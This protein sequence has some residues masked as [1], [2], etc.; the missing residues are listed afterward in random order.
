MTTAL[1]IVK[2]MP[3]PATRMIRA[4]RIGCRVLAFVGVSA[5]R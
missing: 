1:L 2:G 3:F 4:Y 5:S